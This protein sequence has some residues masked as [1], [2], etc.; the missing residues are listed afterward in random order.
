MAEHPQEDGCAGPDTFAHLR[1]NAPPRRITDSSAPARTITDD[2]ADGPLWSLFPFQSPTG[3][4][5]MY[6]RFDQVRQLW[7]A[8][9]EW[10]RKTR[11]GQLGVFR[12]LRLGNYA[13]VSIP[14]AQAI[15][16]QEERERLPGIFSASE[17]TPQSPAPSA[18]LK[19]IITEF[20]GTR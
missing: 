2:W 9:E 17:L 11:G 6:P 13:H 19:Q 5:S 4:P 1:N 15:M 20:G 10:S 7:Q 16:T 14:W 8:L 12:R 3:P 18:R